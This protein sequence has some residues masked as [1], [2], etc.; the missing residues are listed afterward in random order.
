MCVASTAAQAKDS[1]GAGAADVA[2]I[3]RRFYA[4][5]DGRQQLLAACAVVLQAGARRMRAMHKL[6]AHKRQQKRQKE[7]REASER[8]QLRE[9]QVA[10]ERRKKAERVQPG[11]QETRRRTES[12][13][14]A[15]PASARAATAA[16]AAASMAMVAAVA[17]EA[18]QGGAQLAAASAKLPA[19]RRIAEAAL[20]AR[21][22]ALTEREAAVAGAEAA[23]ALAARE[24]ALVV[25]EA[26]LAEAEAAVTAREAA[27][28]IAAVEE[29]PAWLREA[30]SELGKGEAAQ[31]A[32]GGPGAQ[33]LARALTVARREALWEEARTGKPARPLG[34][35]AMVIAKARPWVDPPP[36][37]KRTGG[38]QR[39]T[40]REVKSERAAEASDEGTLVAV[41]E[42][43]AMAASLE[44]ARE[45]RER[46]Q[47]L[48]VEGAR[49]LCRALLESLREEEAAGRGLGSDAYE[50]LEAAE[51]EARL[52]ELCEL[53]DIA[54]DDTRSREALREAASA[55]GQAAGAVPKRGRASERVDEMV[56]ARKCRTAGVN[57]GKNKRSTAA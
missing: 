51:G 29:E 1:G 34:V 52:E 56:F 32:A 27:R 18:T 26:A 14:W 31:G 22:A 17:E 42:S 41:E 47:R 21:E 9:Q 37:P 43:Q 13:T 33:T 25:R 8:L 54:T 3:R 6:R 20:A 11:R 49:E 15:P 28:E 12:T 40:W 45:G 5:L 57:L 4:A 48:R 30:S 24:A 55:P 36:P 7:V 10:E 23:E 39:K 50:E 35:A 19:S 53:A 44:S 16:A 38:R 46:E 2:A